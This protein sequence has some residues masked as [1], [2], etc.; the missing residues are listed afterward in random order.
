MT[1]YELIHKITEST[2]FKRKDVLAIVEQL[3]VVVKDAV[4][5]GDEVTLR[6]FGSFWR[7]HRDDYRH[8]APGTIKLV[9][10]HNE[11]R[12]KPSKK[13]KALLLKDGI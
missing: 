6:G 10:A 5:E 2:G 8:Y 9:P 7:Q 11:P 13:F 4:A 1:K 12:F 3:M